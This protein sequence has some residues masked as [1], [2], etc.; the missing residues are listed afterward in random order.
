MDNIKKNIKQYFPI[1]INEQKAKSHNI[2]NIE[3]I[4]IYFPYKPYPQQKTYMEKV[5]STLNNQGSISA[6]ESPTGT[7]KTLCLLCAI[8]G[9][10]QQTK[11]EI[12][13]YYGTRTVSQINN[14]L[15]ELKKTCYNLQFSFLASRVHTC[16]KF[17]KNQRIKMD[18]QILYVNTMLMK[19]LN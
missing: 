19:T 14:V 9:W 10:M 13:I 15:K 5:V 18:N 2:V 11:K 4:K 7:G 1:E 3:G 6:L 12:S 16:L 17:H 8:L